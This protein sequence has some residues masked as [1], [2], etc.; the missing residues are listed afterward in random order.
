MVTLPMTLSVA[1]HALETAP[2]MHFAPPFIASQREHLETSDHVY[3]LA[4]A[5]PTLSIKNHPWKVHGQ[6]HVTRFFRFLEFYIQWNISWT[7]SHIWLDTSDFVHGGRVNHQ[8]CGR[9]QD[10]VSNSTFWTYKTSRHQV[11]GVL[12]WSTNSSTV[13]LCITHTTVEHVV[14]EW[15]Y[16]GRL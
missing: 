1:N 9:G 10:Q 15:N 4:I 6:S 16:V 12:E 11:V 13:S 14:A 5:S 2:F 3:G 8:P 7:A